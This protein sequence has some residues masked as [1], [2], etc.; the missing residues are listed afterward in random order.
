MRPTVPEIFRAL[1][2]A[3]LMC[4]ALACAAPGREKLLA[5]QAPESYQ[6]RIMLVLEREDFRPVPGAEIRVESDT[7]LLKPAGGA[8]R[9]DARGGLELVFQPL[10]HYDQSAWAGGDIIVEY[11]IKARLLIKRPGRADLEVE[12][13]ERETFA[14][15][16][17]PLYQALNR[18][19]EPG[20]TYY[21]VVVP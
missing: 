18:D 9:T 14:R 8:G 1:G 10:P 17:D 19:P 13:S 16:A 2:A 20:L 5:P 21:T 3:L 12:L 4:A 6:R 11:P 15:Y 7:T